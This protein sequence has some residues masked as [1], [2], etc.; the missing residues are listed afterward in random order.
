MTNITVAI[1]VLLMR[2]IS[3][4]CLFDLEIY[5]PHWEHWILLIVIAKLNNQFH[6]IVIVDMSFMLLSHPCLLSDCLLLFLQSQHNEI[7]SNLFWWYA[8]SSNLGTQN[9]RFWWTPP[10]ISDWNCVVIEN[11]ISSGTAELFSL[12]IW[13][14]VHTWFQVLMH[15]SC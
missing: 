6:Q 11:R 9:I 10:H 12:L 14:P 5:D 2:S 8:A 13:I 1:L 7:S 15:W 4:L 3:T